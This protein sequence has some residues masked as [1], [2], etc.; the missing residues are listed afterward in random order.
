MKTIKN[1]AYQDATTADLIGQ[2]INIAWSWISVK[3]MRDRINVLNKIEKLKAWDDIKLEEAEYVIV[4]KCVDETQ[5]RVVSKDI[6]SF[7]DEIDNA[8]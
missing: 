1:S 2:C 6:I 8:T 4:K 5:W 3:E 7:S